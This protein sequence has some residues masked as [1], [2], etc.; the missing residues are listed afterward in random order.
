MPRSCLAGLSLAVVFMLC[1]TTG[2]ASAGQRHVARDQKQ[3]TPARPWMDA[4][5][6][7]D[8][9][10]NLVAKELT[11]DEELSLVSGYMGYSIAGFPGPAAP[12]GALGSAGFIPG[13]PRLGIPALEETDASLGVTNPLN[14]RQGDYAT[15]L[16]SGLATAATFDSRA[17]YAGGAMIGK[18][19]WD[20][21]FDV[22]L[23]PG[24]NLT[25]D[26]RN[27]RNFEYLGE[28]PLLTGTLAGA[29]IRGIQDQHV[30][31]TLKHFAVNDQETMRNWANSVIDE[32]AMRESDLLAF[33]LAI[34]EGR[35][36]AVMCS[37]NLVNG[38]WA[39][40]NKHLLTDV[41]KTDWG[42]PGFVM[43]DWGAV[44]DTSYALAGL[45][46]ESAAS[47][48][49]K[50]F[51]RQPLKDAIANG[52][53][54]QSR[55]SD[56]VHRILRSMFAAGV[57]DHPPA[58]TAIDYKT[59]GD[60]AQQD[61]EEGIVL[62][63]NKDGV[64]PFAANVKRI[65]IIG[66]YAANGVLSGGGSSQVIPSG[67]YITIPLGGTGFALFRTMIYDPSSPMAA[68]A[69]LAPNA[70]IRFDDGRYLSSAAKLAKWADIA[71][72][73]AGQWMTEGSDAPSLNLPDGQD[74]LISAVAAANPKTVAVLETGGP[75]KMP[76][77]DNVTAVLE[78]WY[79]GGRGGEAIANVLF[80]QVNPSGHLPITFPQ[81]IAQEP[82][83]VIP[84]SDLAELPFGVGGPP[85]GVKPFD[86][87][88]TEGAKVGYRWFAEK[89]LKPL[90]PFG[91]GLSYTTFG[92]TNLSVDGGKTLTVSFDVTN[93]GDRAGADVPQVYLIS[94]A[95]QPQLR[96]I[97]F[98]R[99][100]LAPGQTKHVSLT[101]DPRLLADF[102]PAANEW[103]VAAGQYSISVSH[104]ATDSALTGT[105]SLE[106]ATI[107]P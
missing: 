85:S 27:G 43:S 32:A 13:I 80:G 68:I 20:K 31:A 15:P 93:T 88:Y 91:F 81:D 18:E 73:F 2:V 98:S 35:P 19:A 83:P 84:G 76:W 4:S 14:A 48:D 58:P 55:L 95:G 23:G 67:H 71:I 59:D 101:A 82:R 53:I 63:K 10:A 65:A 30:I 33:E 46:Q 41:L 8:Q 86:V 50:P 54:P 61:A 78:A 6:G 56:M 90:F 12:K 38:A 100:R 42:W 96:L 26:P 64:L 75:V 66:G 25:R 37:Y 77:L 17:A 97:G 106:A 49:Y 7:P 62:L 24:A 39:C 105:A 34:D 104:S 40:D 79:P 45:D 52:T 21:G 5:L 44:H 69:A 107:K 70:S 94:E 47:L 28:D 36:G 51:F 72:V 57:V 87:A 103:A 11:E 99:V 3:A 29:T 1:V 92:Y 22:L 74:A 89:N 102:D 16:P 9:R 60:V